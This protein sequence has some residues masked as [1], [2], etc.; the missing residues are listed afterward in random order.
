MNV[1]RGLFRLWVVAAAL[2]AV[3]MGL[4]YWREIT[5][6]Y[7]PL[8]SFVY[9]A[10]GADLPQELSP[11]DL[12]TDGKTGPYFQLTDPFNTRV[13]GSAYKII[14]LP[15]EIKLF[16]AK[17]IGDAETNNI[18]D[19]FWTRFGIPRDAEIAEKRWGTIKQALWAVLVPPFVVLV[20]GGALAWAFSG[21]KKK[22]QT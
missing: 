5:A 15:N 19:D 17:S 11:F 9:K 3:A 12:V 14:I 18:V 20:I 22:H 4:L 16:L 1:R 10:P 8:Q 6:P 21:F 2:W 13:P 7:I